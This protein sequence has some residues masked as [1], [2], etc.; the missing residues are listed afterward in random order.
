[1][2]P[3]GG[4]SVDF[5]DQLQEMNKPKVERKAWMDEKVMELVTEETL[6][7][8]VNECINSESG[9]YAWDV[10]TTGLDSRVFY[11]E[12][13]TATTVDK[14]VGHCLSPDGIHGYYIP[15]RHRDEAGDNHPANIPP[16]V[17][18]KAFKRLADS[19]AIAIFHNGKFDHEMLQFGESVTLGEWDDPAS[20]EDTIILAYLRNTRERRKGLKLLALSELGYEMIDL[21]EL[22]TAEQQ[23]KGGLNFAQ[24]DPTWEPA[25]WYGC[26]DAICTYQLCMGQPP[27]EGDHD[28][29]FRGLHATVMDPEPTGLSQATVYKI[30]KMTLPA[31]RWMERCRIKIDRNKV[32]ELIQLGQAEWFQS[33]DA[34]YTE[35]QKILGRSVR[36]GWFLLMAG[37]AEGVG[38]AADHYKFDPLEMSP[39]YMAAKKDADKGAAQF[40]IDPTAPDGKGK[41]RVRTII[42]EVPTLM[43]P[44][45]KEN[46]AFL[47]VYDVTIPAQLGMML[48]EMGVKGLKATEKSGQVKTDQKTLDYIIETAAKQFPFMGKIQRFRQIKTALANNLFP[49]LLD[50][51]PKRAPDGCVRVNFNGH[52]VDTGRF[53]TPKPR[54]KEYFGQVRWNLHSIPAG[55]EKDRP[56]CMLRI[57]EC[58]QARPGKILFAIDYAG[59]ELRIV[60]NISGEP[61]WLD[62]FFRCSS[63]DHK[64][65]RSK[66]DPPP[67]FCPNVLPNG[68]V[69]KSDKIGD[70]HSLTAFAVYG[71]GIKGTKDFKGKRQKSKCVH[72]DTLITTAQGRTR[73]GDLDFGSEDTF[74]PVSG[75]EVLNPD[76]QHITV[77]ETYNGGVKSLFHVITRRGVL[78]C[79]DAHRFVLADGSLKSV[80]EGLAPGD[81]LPNPTTHLEEDRGF[82]EVSH[83][84]FKGIP[85]LTYQTTTQTAYF[86]GLHA[87]D[88]CSSEACA[89]ISHGPVGEIDLL[90]V[91]YK[92]WQDIIMDVCLA[93]GLEPT[94]RQTKVYLGSRHVL[95]WMQTLGLVEGSP[96]TKRTFRVPSWVLQAG[97]VAILHYLGGLIDTDGTVSVNGDLSITT[98]DFVFAGQIADLLRAV[99]CVAAVSKS[100]NKLYQRHYLKVSVKRRDGKTLRPYIRHPGKKARISETEVGYDRGD[101]EVLLV[102]PAGEGP[103]VDLHIDSSDHLYTA[104]GLAVHN[105][106]NFAMCYGG[107]PQAAMRAIDVDKDEA[108][109]IKRQFDGSYSGLTA[110]WKRQ[111]NFARKYKFVNTAFGRRYPLPDI[112]HEM[113]GF[114]SKAERNAVNGPIQGCLHPNTRIATSEG[115]IPV[116]DLHA[117][118]TPFKVWTGQ[119]WSEARPLFSG[120]KPVRVTE[121]SPGTTIRTSPEHLFLS[122]RQT[123]DSPQN[124]GDVLEWIRQN[125]LEPSDWV[126]MSTSVLEWPEPRYQWESETRPQEGHQFSQGMTPHNYKGFSICGNSEALWEF[127]GLIYGDGSIGAKKLTVH[128]GEPQI[129]GYTG[130]SAEETANLYRDR[131]NTALNVGAHAYRKVRPEQESHKQDMWQVQVCNKAFRDFCRDVLGVFDQNTY[132]K[133]FPNALWKESV[134]NRAAFLR[135]YFSADGSVSTTGDTASVRSVN[136]GLLRDAHDLLRTIGIRSSL[137]PKSLRVTVLDRVKY[138]E[139]VGFTMPHKNERLAAMKMNPW[140]YQWD[141]APPGLVRWV[142]EIVYGSS[143]Y[144]G[145]PKAQKSAVLRLK[146][147]SGS[148]HQCSKYLH[149]LPIAE[150]PEALQE[151]LEYDWEQVVS[152]TDPD[153]TVDMYD[154]E[155][156]DDFHA[157]VADGCVVHNT[158]ADITKLAMALVFRLCKKRGWLRRVLLT[159]TIHDEL[160]FEIDEAIAEEACALIVE[161]MTRNKALMRLPHPVP[162]KC[163]V[164]FGR[165]WTV[166]H[167]LTE[168][169]YNAENDKT[170][171]LPGGGQWTE[172]LAKIFPKSYASFLAHAGVPLEGFDAPDVPVPAA[173]GEPLGAAPK[174]VMMM[175]GGEVFQ[176]PETGSGKVCIHVVHS[177]RLSYGLMNQLAEVIAKVEGRGLETL[178]VETEDGIILYDNPGILISA[179][180]FK[181]LAGE[182]RV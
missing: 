59:V 31:T 169:A 71:E 44:K 151:L 50:T 55:Y 6:D 66:E 159:I 165:D 127:L 158:S 160:V 23:K 17:A 86:A 83:H 38:A 91:P 154:V 7:R 128:V 177:S 104:N 11:G 30:E 137:R 133:R 90:G 163:D 153:V 43:N 138:R 25:I 180:E 79:S 88:G 116:G 157:F 89:E 16:T 27:T 143:I 15:V 162:Y 135:G 68:K 144:A 118:G 155:V 54:I 108:Y 1:V 120:P 123:S 99:G 67:P 78:T 29:G 2:T 74:L 63:C 125:D 136:L 166:P 47:T 39:D 122:W 139:V 102:L 51:T 146:K 80:G 178:R 45:K 9:H 150:Q 176:A 35:A 20:Y 106:L 24:L 142:G 41:E 112:D 84:L 175:A 81:V 115:L 170:K 96:P 95:R 97:R 174:P 131:L 49:I 60:T 8:V 13:G 65:K 75:V 148:R 58:V 56:E 179:V 12:D 103:C 149:Q 87:G 92:D 26:S 171:H 52:K 145:L 168:M 70:L 69:C 152:S 94:A 182:Y 5:F 111:Q 14:I 172:Q 93:V 173:E 22:F 107:G 61:K 181:V 161:E 117:A 134:K 82:P 72:P 147:G 164:E 126:A 40:R 4:I 33:L 124:K 130:P 129:E 34:V 62:E 141:L 110:W 18:N 32:K 21:H 46:V 140:L 132:T 19:K 73:I 109:R 101:N 76:G 3:T 28:S 167:N 48:R 114:R 85:T 77:K 57:R 36:P 98:K 121:F 53:A 156:L 119:G 64:F 42:K 113:G 105:S 100:W 37:T 10:E